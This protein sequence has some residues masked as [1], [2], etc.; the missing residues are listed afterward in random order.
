MKM[1]FAA[2]I[3]TNL[4][5]DEVADHARVAEESGYSHIAYVDQPNMNPDAFVMMT[6]AALSTHRI[7]IG[8]GVTDPSTYRP[9][10]IAN[11]TASVNELSG[12]RAFIGIG[13]GGPWGKI[14][15]PIPQRQFR[16]AVLFIRKYLAGEEAEF[17]GVKMHSAWIPRPVPI[18]MAASGPRACEQSG[19]LGDGVILSIG[20]NPTILKWRMEYVEKGAL[21]AGRDP[22]K[23]DIWIQTMIYVADS[24]EAARREVAAYVA[25]QANGA[26]WLL[27]QRHKPEI[28]D[29]CQRLEREHPG[30][31]GE[32][33]KIY[34]GYD[35]YQHERTGAP[36]GKL[37]TQRVIDFFHLTGTPEDICEQIYKV[38]QTG[39]KTICAA[40]YT[41]IDKKSMMREIGDRIMPHFRN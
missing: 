24:K 16:E 36:Q 14:M 19:E 28:E 29:L 2:A 18:Y 11:A 13:A 22:S 27:R 20:I 25:T 41:I 17:Q 3:G 35:Y 33:K 6:V 39:V 34:D 30:I 9:W 21:K 26:Y 40:L 8:Q 1:K 7:H 37:V 23:L 32:F 5:M 12:G 4:R 38:G 31:I 10:V 15:K